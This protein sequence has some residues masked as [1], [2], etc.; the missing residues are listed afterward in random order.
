M[1]L[2][3]PRSL[4]SWLDYLEHR[5]AEPIQL[6]LTRV[7]A[8][9]SKLNL[10]QLGACVITVAGTN[11]KGSTVAALEAIYVEAGFQV[12]V[13]T[14]PHLLTFNERICVNQ[15]PISDEALCSAFSVIEAAHEDDYLTY[16]EM[17]TLAALY[18]FKHSA[19]DVIILEVGMGGRLD[20][21][22]IIDA[23]LAIITTIALDHEAY[24]GD[25]LELIG[26]EKAGILRENQLFI[27]ADTQPPN[28]IIQRAHELNTKCLC[29][30][31]DYWLNETQDHLVIERPDADLIV[32]PRPNLNRFAA[33]AAIMASD[34]L[35]ARLPVTHLQWANAM[36]R[37]KILGRQQVFSGNVSTLVDV[38][39]NPQS[40]ELL[41][42][43]IKTK[44]PLGKIHAVFSALKDKDLP[45]LIKPM[46]DVVDDWYI[47][48]LEG[49]RAAPEALLL[50]AVHAESSAQIQCFCDPV[51][52][53]VAAMQ[54]AMPGDFVVV[55]GSF[56]TASAVL[57]FKKQ[58]K[59]NEI[60]N[61]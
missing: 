33:A 37:V 32:L 34:A 56:L 28:T 23:D 52:A 14:S 18:H 2:Q 41:A 7:H 9:A 13:Y 31:V 44:R 16:F 25:S 12:G 1:S 50:A 47:A 27:Y 46:Q 20:A 58:E 35:R 55:Y 4:P 19:L 38:A 39:H 48:G 10:C 36:Q 24:L 45:G 54:Q 21:T 51:S 3:A 11:G 15:Q 43:W 17:T 40:V 61:G 29:R 42:Q 26:H 5:H 22:N 57:A 8:V 49:P 53:Y 60:C 59:Q 30:G 6:G